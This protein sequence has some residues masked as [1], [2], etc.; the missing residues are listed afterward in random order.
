MSCVTCHFSR[1]T[2]LKYRYFYICF[3]FKQ[4]IWSGWARWLRVCYQWGLP[5]LVNR[6]SVARAVLQTPLILIDSLTDKSF[7]S[8][9]RLQFWDKVHPP[10]CDTYQVSGVMR[11]MS[12]VRCHMAGVGCHFFIIKWWSLLLEGLLSVGPTPSSLKTHANYLSSPN[13]GLKSSILGY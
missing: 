4:K 3:C 7:S 8:K 9:L 5:R 13:M 12:G 1:F 2:C 11:H 6:S 10:P